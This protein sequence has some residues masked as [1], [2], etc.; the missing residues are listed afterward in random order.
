MSVRVP[1][2]VLIATRN[3]ARNLRRCLDPLVNWA[4]EIVVADSASSDDTVAIA[5]SCGATVIQFSYRGGWPKKRQ[6]TMDSFP[7]RTDWILLLH[8]DEILLDSIRREIGDVVRA[9]QH[10][11]Y[12]LRFQI[13]FLGRQLRFGDTE[14]W[15]LSLFRKG[16][17]R[18]ERRLIAQ[19]ASMSDIEVH[20]HVVVT[21]TTGR[22]TNSVR[23]DNWNSLDRYIEK[24]NQYSN[25]DARVQHERLDGEIAPAFW[26][27][28]AARRRWLKR[29]LLRVPGSPFLWLT[30]KYIWKLGMLDGIPGLIYCGLQAIQMFHIKAKM[31][32]MRITGSPL[33]ESG[34]K[35]TVAPREKSSGEIT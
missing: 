13:H 7:F 15:K 2:S 32:E 20:E 14:L 4:D 11:G 8:A 25:W 30:H 16:A 6:S 5:E 26:G 35:S 21:G 10:D 18:Y 27:N 1:I 23:H 33:S 17:G 29:S 22:L 28:Q 12:W 31:Y 34:T 19:D 9:G 3:E 24:H